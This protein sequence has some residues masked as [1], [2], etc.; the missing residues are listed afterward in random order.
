MSAQLTGSEPASRDRP[1]D[2]HPAYRLPMRIAF[3]AE[4]WFWRGPAP[5]HCVT[6][7]PRESELITEIAPHVTYG[8]GMV[9]AVVRIGGTSTT[10]SLWPKEAGCVVPLKKALREEEGV[11][12]GDEVHVTLEISP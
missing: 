10:T 9:P 5:F 12:L 4:V 2:A 8:W 1:R 7:P 11:E 3:T 6:A